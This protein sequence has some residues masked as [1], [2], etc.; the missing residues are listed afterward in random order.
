MHRGTNEVSLTSLGVVGKPEIAG[1]DVDALLAAARVAIGQ[2]RHRV[3]TSD[4]DCGRLIAELG[5]GRGELGSELAFSRVTLRAV[6]H[7]QGDHRANACR[8]GGGA[9]ET[10]FPWHRLDVPVVPRASLWAA[11]DP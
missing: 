8:H 9:R 2:G 6:A 7:D 4:T 10:V 3:D 11:S 1:Q 5:S